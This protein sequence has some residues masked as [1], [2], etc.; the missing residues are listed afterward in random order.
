MSVDFKVIGERIREARI[1]AGITQEDLSEMLDI[2]VAF[3]SRVER[4]KAQ[5]NLKRLA[6][7]SRVLDVPLEEL[8]SGSTTDSKKYL[9]KDL[10]KIYEKCDA[11]QQKLIYN[12]A[13]IISNTKLR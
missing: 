1:K 7:I 3:I 12:V 5:V 9:D 10:A 8:V 6:Q 2:T 4:G 13:K 11:D